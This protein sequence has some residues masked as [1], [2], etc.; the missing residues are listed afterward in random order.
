MISRR[1]FLGGAAALGAST[2]LY[3]AAVEP[4]WLRV[5]RTECPLPGLPAGQTIRVLHLSD[6]HASTVVPESLIE[7]AIA[8]GMALQPDL[9]CLTG[10][11]VTRARGY[12]RRWY[13]E[14]LRRLPQVA[15]AFAVLG[16]HD[17]GRWAWRRRGFRTSR[18]VATLLEESGIT[19]LSNR[20]VQ[21]RETGLTLIG[22]ADLWSGEMD[23]HA[24]FRAA[25]AGPRL[26]L[27]HNPDTK[28]SLRAYPWSLMLSGH[29]HGGQVVWPFLGPRFAPV[30]DKRYVR[31]LKA[32]GGR[33]IHVSPGVGNVYG[34]RLN[35]RPEVNLLLLTGAVESG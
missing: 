6:L 20:A 1:A 27:A 29:T 26:V 5:T 13:V 30:R 35:C 22:M 32:W 12:D 18:E 3:G 21:L 15:P 23:A 2:A 28:D 9:I 11:F 16:N 24:A 34:V 31:G 7:R 8:A 4:N 25:G 17:G 33:W 10:D 14:T 19:V